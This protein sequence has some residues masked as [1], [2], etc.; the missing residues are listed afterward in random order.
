MLAGIREFGG[1]E[2]AGPARGTFLWL[3]RVRFLS[4][5]Y[6]RHG[7]VHAPMGRSTRATRMRACASS[8]YGRTRISLA[9]RRWQDGD[10]WEGIWDDR[11]VRALEP[12]ETLVLLGYR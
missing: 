10:G 3:P 2:L 11:A 7:Y 9:I 5:I 6:P 12:R 4:Y 1:S 8:F